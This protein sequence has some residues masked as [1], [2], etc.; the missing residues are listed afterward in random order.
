MSFK[1]AG[2]R[3]E[4]PGAAQIVEHSGHG[5]LF[6]TILSAFAL[7]I[8]GLSYYESSL[9][10]AD[11]TVYVPPMIHYARDGSA[12]VFNIPITIAN[13]GAKNGTVL[14]MELE[15]EN[16]RADAETKTRRFH[17]AFLGD[18]PKDDKT[19]TGRSR[20]YRSPATAPSPR[21]CGSTRWTT[22]TTSWSTTRATIASR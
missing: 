22:A 19:P 8:S 13:D 9:K 21:R 12:D 3:G 16:L 15:V 14:T 6:A 2:Q 20:R 5:G 11:L 7:V 17:S 10:T 1:I 4:D 18:W